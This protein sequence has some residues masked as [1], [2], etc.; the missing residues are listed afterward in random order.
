MS[1]TRQLPLRAKRKPSGVKTFL[2]AA[3]VALTIVCAAALWWLSLPLIEPDNLNDYGLVA[4]LPWKFWAAL[5]ILSL[6]F[7]ASLSNAFPRP[8]LRPVALIMLIVMLHATPPIVY[9]T[10]RYSWAWKHIGLVDFIQ[11]HGEVDRTLPFLTAYHN[12]PALFWLSAKWADYSGWGPLELANAVRFTSIPTNI[13]FAAIIG[14][15]FRVFT[16]DT[17]HIWAGLWIFVC[18]NWIGQ[19]YYSPQAFAYALYL[20][21]LWLCL[22]PLMPQG[23]TKKAAFTR[24]GANGTRLMSTPPEKRSTGLWL[25][26]ALIPLV[27]VLIAGIVASHQLTP[28]I[29][30]CSLIGVAVVTP[31]SYGYALMVG[32]AVAYWILYPAAPYT[33]IIIPKEIAELGNTVESISDRLVKTSTVTPEMAVVVWAG[34]AVAGAATLLAIIGWV[35]RWQTRK[36]DSALLVLLVAPGF[37]LGLTSYGGEAL[38]RIYFFCLPFLSFFA[39][40][41]F[42]PGHARPISWASWLG[43]TLLIPLLA[44][45]FLFGNNGKDRQYRFSKDEVEAAHWLY[46]RAGPDT[47]LVEGSRNYPSQ[48]MHYEYFTYVPISRELPAAQAEIFADPETV[49]AS[50]FENPAWQDGYIVLTR[51]QKTFAETI[52]AVEK[53]A[54]DQLERALIASSEFLLVYANKDARIFRARR[55][56]VFE[57]N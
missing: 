38:F 32:L 47:L 33:S 53:G 30:L 57:R 27:L 35:R 1:S 41:A 5:L 18:A 29:L 4:I 34:R 50:W 51:S 21:V 10:L 2:F 26:T 40:A 7:S 54:L 17:R 48:F 20:L 46:S 52:G 36:R 15:I 42:F 43:F 12:W 8:E 31:L 11:R 44:L 37:V 14:A 23:V 19:D 56:V 22:G 49:L 13:I 6:G 3:G 45:G 28:L 39:A 55:F 9:D 25:K 16:N 24:T